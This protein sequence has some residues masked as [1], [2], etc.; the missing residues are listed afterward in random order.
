MLLQAR[1][2]PSFAQPF[3]A[4]PSDRP[5]TNAKT[6]NFASKKLKRTG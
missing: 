4:M 6:P 3:F 2:M 5:L 1:P